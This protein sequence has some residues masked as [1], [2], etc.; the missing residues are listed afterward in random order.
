MEN[1]HFQWANPLLMV[2]FNSYVKLPEVICVFL[3]ANAAVFGT[4]TTRKNN[5]DLPKNHFHN[6]YLIIA[7]GYQVFDVVSSSQ[8][9]KSSSHHLVAGRS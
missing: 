1:H 2:I 9:W 8:L 5:Y 6:W 3:G 4:A 7:G